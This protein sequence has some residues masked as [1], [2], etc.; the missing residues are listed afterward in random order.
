MDVRDI[1]T[2]QDIEAYYEGIEKEDILYWESQPKTA[3]MTAQEFDELENVA[4]ERYRR[5]KAAGKAGYCFFSDYRASAWSDAARGVSPGEWFR[6]WHG[7]YP[8]YYSTWDHSPKYNQQ[9]RYYI[10][11]ALACGLADS[12]ADA[13]QYFKDNK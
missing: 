9:A 13:V 2:K 5:D 1:S 8:C 7:N 3:P 4:L 12:A 6:V 11:K 10:N